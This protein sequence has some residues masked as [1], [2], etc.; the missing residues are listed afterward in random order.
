MTDR[1]ERP[2]RPEPGPLAD[3]DIA[4]FCGGEGSRIKHI[5]GDT[6]KCL[7]P[8]KGKPLI[9]HLLGYLRGSGGRSFWLLASDR[10]Y[11][12][13]QRWFHST[14]DR[15]GVSL[16]NEGEPRGTALALRGLTV[17]LPS[18]RKGRSIGRVM[19]LNGD[20]LLRGDIGG[21][22]VANDVE[23][24]AGSISTGVFMTCRA[25]LVEPMIC[26]RVIDVIFGF[27]FLDIGTPEGYARAE[28]WLDAP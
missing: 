18:H 15:D 24:F 17:H 3:L 6:P 26:C 14:D 7:A 11:P 12:A 13:L 5:L 20:T 4:I 23:F 21:L 1:P 25:A 2:E 10:S 22:S 8:I 9:E 16:I 27:S 19:V 28:A